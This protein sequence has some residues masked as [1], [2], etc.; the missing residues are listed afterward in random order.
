MLYQIS[1]GDIWE[2]TIDNFCGTL[3]FAL[4][5]A[6]VFPFDIPFG[7]PGKIRSVAVWRPR[8]V[9]ADR[10]NLTPKHRQ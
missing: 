7:Y 4:L 6:T 2:L 5:Q 10:L 3:K 8:S 1:E 9:I